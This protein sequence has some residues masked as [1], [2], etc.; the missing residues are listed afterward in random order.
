MTFGLVVAL[1]IGEVG[2]RWIG[3]E[4]FN[5]TEIRRRTVG[6]IRI[7]PGGK[8]VEP[9]PLLGF[10][11]V[12]GRVRVHFGDLDFVATHDKEHHRITSSV[13]DKTSSDGPELWVIGCSFAHGFGVEDEE[14]FSFLLQQARPNWRVTNMGLES[15]NTVQG[16]MEVESLLHQKRKPRVVLLAYAGFHEIRNVSLRIRRR[17]L[18]P[19]NPLMGDV[20]VPFARLNDMNKIEFY[21]DSLRYV[22]APLARWSSIVDLIDLIGTAQELER[23]RKEEVTRALLK[24]FD[25]LCLDHGAKF[26]VAGVWPDSKAGLDWCQGHQIRHVD[27]SFD[28]STDEYLTDSKND[29]HPGPKGHRHYAE[30]LLPMLDEL[31][32]D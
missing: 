26:L 23:S 10:V 20:R 1:V 28:T 32:V 8:L 22:E 24:L 13:K 30:K 19:A 4:P 25:Q 5:P 7:E 31:M 12:P 16:Y 17:E 14:V 2:L 3:F 27:V 15:A 6:E 11:N 18:S 29:R 9:D 21:Y